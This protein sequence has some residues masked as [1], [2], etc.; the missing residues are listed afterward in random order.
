MGSAEPI[1]RHEKT[2][3]RISFFTRSRPLVFAVGADPRVCPFQSEVGVRILKAGCPYLYVIK[4]LGFEVINDPS[5]LFTLALRVLRLP[6][7]I[8]QGSFPVVEI[9]PQFVQFPLP[10]ANLTA[11]IADTFFVLGILAPQPVLLVGDLIVQLLDFLPGLVNRVGRVIV[12]Q[13]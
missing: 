9:V 4:S 1:V 12:T 10:V 2:V 13:E 3:S 8:V 5:T 7:Q 6:H 11:Q